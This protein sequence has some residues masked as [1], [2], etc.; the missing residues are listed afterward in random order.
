VKTALELLGADGTGVFGY[1]SRD[2]ELV[3][4]RA[5]E[6]MR[7]AAVA[8]A[9]AQPPGDRACSL[10]PDQCERCEYEAIVAGRIRELPVKP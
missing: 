8:A 3:A 9:L 5:R 4:Q 1:S 2:L 7:E 10:G 6:E